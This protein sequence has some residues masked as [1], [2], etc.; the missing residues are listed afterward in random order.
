M[1]KLFITEKDIQNEY[2]ITMIYLNWINIGECFTVEFLDYVKDELTAIIHLNGKPWRTL[3]ATDRSRYDR[4]GVPSAMT[5]RGKIEAS[6]KYIRRGLL[7]S[8]LVVRWRDCIGCVTMANEDY[9]LDPDG[10]TPRPGATRDQ[11]CMYHW[12]NQHVTVIEKIKQVD[13]W[14]VAI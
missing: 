9:Q 6:E 11:E 7:P 2:E 3:F 14:P 5:N 8:I 1:S 10:R 13:E 4:L 12:H